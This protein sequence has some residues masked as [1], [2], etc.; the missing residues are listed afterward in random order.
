[1]HDTANNWLELLHKEHVRGDRLYQ[2]FQNWAY[3]P[4]SSSFSDYLQKLP[5]ET[6]DVLTEYQVFYAKDLIARALFEAHFE[7]GKLVSRMTP[8]L[9]DAILAARGAADEKQ[10]IRKFASDHREMKLVD[11]QRWPNAALH[12]FRTTRMRR[13]LC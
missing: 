8:E 6:R 13:V 5:A 2:H 4:G 11:T 12:G 1:M 9:Q 10:Q 3:S 7:G